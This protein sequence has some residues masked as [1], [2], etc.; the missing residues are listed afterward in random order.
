MAALREF[1]SLPDPAVSSNSEELRAIEEQARANSAA[2][3]FP[4][5]DVA[6]VLVCAAAAGWFCWK[7]L[8]KVWATF[9]GMLRDVR[10]A[11]R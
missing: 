1:P 4:M 6:I 11:L 7:V 8:P 3:P 10:N 9:I 2:D 5:A